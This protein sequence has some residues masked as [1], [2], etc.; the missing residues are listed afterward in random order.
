MRAG[1]LAGSCPTSSTAIGDSDEIIA[2]LIAISQLAIDADLT[3]EQRN[4]SLMLRR[5]LD[6]LNWVMS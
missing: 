4:L 6:D 3:R 5:T 2:H 1:R